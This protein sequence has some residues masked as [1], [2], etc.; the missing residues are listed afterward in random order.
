MQQEYLHKQVRC[1][2]G[3]LGSAATQWCV[4][5]PSAVC[6]P[7]TLNSHH[8]APTATLQCRVWIAVRS[9]CCCM[10][11]PARAWCAR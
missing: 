5:V 8:H 1:G 3:H 2:E 10:C 7:S 4:N 11:G 9:R 6:Y